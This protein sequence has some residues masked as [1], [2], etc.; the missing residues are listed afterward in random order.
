MDLIVRL[1]AAAEVE[2]AFS[3]YEQQ[4]PGLGEEFLDVVDEALREIAAY[5]LRQAVLFRDMR[6]LLLKRFPYAVFYRVYPGT[7]AVV[8]C[9]H[10]RRNP[11]RWKR[12]T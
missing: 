8:A 2:E 12:R 4:R 6:R 9:M 5:P 1:A 3:W 7:I 11:L 10:A